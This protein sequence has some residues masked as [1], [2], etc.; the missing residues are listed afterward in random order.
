MVVLDKENL[1]KPITHIVKN[2]GFFFIVFFLQYLI[3]FGLSFVKDNVE[4]KAVDLY[5]L[6]E[7]IYKLICDFFIKKKQKKHF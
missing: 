7:F 1:V 4:E 5:V 2:I 6:G 3:D